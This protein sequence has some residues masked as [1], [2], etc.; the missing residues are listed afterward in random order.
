MYQNQHH[1]H[2]PVMG[3]GHSVDSPIRVAPLGINSVISIVDDLL[4][5]KI[6]KYYY[7]ING[8]KYNNIPV[9]AHDGRARRIT[10]YLNLV[11]KIVQQKFND[12][13]ALPL[14]QHSDKD[15]YFQM[16]PESHPLKTKYNVI[17][18]MADSASQEQAID[19]LTRDMTPGSIDVNIMSKVDALNY[20]SNDQPLSAEFSDANAAL[21]GFA[22]SKLDSA[23]VL[24][25]GFNP[26]LY[27]YL[28]E[29]KDFYRNSDG[30]IKKKIILKVSDFRS[31][32]IQGKYL[33]KKGLEVAEFRIESGL[34]CGGHAFPS[35]GELMPVLLNDFKK[36]RGQLIETF[37]PMVQQYYEA[38]GWTY[39]ELNEADITPALTVQGGIGIHGELQRL[40]HNYSA[41]GTGWGSPF[42]LV[43]EATCVDE[44]TYRLLGEAG[45][46]DLYLS[47]V[48]PFGIPF[49]NVRGTGSEQYTRAQIDKGKPGS[50]CPKGFLV[51]NTE[52]TDKPICTAS[53]E[54]QELKIK[55]LD[56]EDLA[57]E[58]KEHKKNKVM[59]KTCLCRNLGTGALI[60]LGIQ[61][62][63]YGRQ[64]V[65]PGPNIAWF[66]GPYK[67]EEMV[68]HIY[69]R[70]NMLV[71]GERPHMF[72]KELKMYVDYLEELKKHAGTDKSELR[73]IKKIRNNLEKGMEECLKIARSE[74]FGHEN[75]K[76]LEMMVH[77]QR[78]R[79]AEMF[80]T[81]VLN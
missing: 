25:A 5:E 49:N 48:S 4:L 38:Q 29:F 39:P 7:Q 22:N 58:V 34:N 17:A 9:S 59:Q 27:G 41:D 77:T 68:D 46:D 72:A 20:D 23:V 63:S 12:I 37:Q 61:K 47:N 14:F 57:K 28:A 45:E 33:A 15:R 76:S 31:A 53:R 66:E 26:R 70:G 3:L 79:L 30:N 80:A 65:C 24:S 60:R 16:L 75:L 74:P 32:L 42:L 71:P 69:G 8:L 40:M 36:R 78:E 64:A 56:E 44:T 1:F 54:Y 10:A 52:F 21:R 51:T 35:D 81:P 55:Q 62:P 11:Q 2:I 18:G 67:L 50:K 43:P 6:R 13:K 19:E 73:K